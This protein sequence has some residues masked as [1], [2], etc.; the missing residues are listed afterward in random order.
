MN[1]APFP[2]LTVRSGFTLIELLTVI[3]IIGILA[4]IIIPTV[5][6]VRASAR[7]TQCKS[8]LRQIGTAALLWSNEN[9]GRIV[10][11]FS[12]NDPNKPLNVRNWTG[13]LAPYVNWRGDISLPSAEFPA[14]DALPVFVCPDNLGTF[15]YGYNYNYLSWPTRPA[16]SPWVTM[17]DVRNPSRIVMMTDSDSSGLG[18]WKPYVRPTSWG[19]AAAPGV[20]FRHPGS[21]ANV[22]WVDGHVSSEAKGSP[23]MAYNATSLRYWDPKS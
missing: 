16:G 23:S 21:V 11:V 5:G 3:A 13:L 20:A 4:A 1:P 12:P 10:P 14:Y 2:R 7:A 18:E 6:R 8:N 15:G 22:V 19:A 17:T 9:K